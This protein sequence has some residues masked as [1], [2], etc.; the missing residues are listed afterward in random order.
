MKNQTLLDKIL[1]PDGLRVLFQPIVEVVGEDENSTENDL[2]NSHEWRLHALECLIRG[3]VGTNIEMPNVLFEYVRNKRAESLIDRVCATKIL[4]A[5]CEVPEDV[6]LS[7]NVHA[8]TL[9]RDRDFPAFLTETALVNGIAHERLIV[10]IVEHV[11]YWDR[12]GFLSVLEGLRAMGVRIALDDVGLGQS[13]Y[14]MMVDCRPDY[15][16]IDRCFVHHAYDDDVRQA[17]LESIVQL[18]RRLGKQTVAEG[19]ENYKDLAGVLKLG[20]NLAQGHLFSH[21]QTL[22]ELIEGDLFGRTNHIKARNF[23]APIEPQSCGAE[24]FI[25]SN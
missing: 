6:H 8:S 18:A 3:P 20:I 2:Q 24:I 10:E 19:V 23:P 22:A 1:E 4:S 14:Q 11:P 16:K 21:A 17:V 12:P 13:N 5:A 15:F 9:G 7:F 25:D